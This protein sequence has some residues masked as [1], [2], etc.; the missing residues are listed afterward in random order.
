M[1][2]RIC[3]RALACQLMGAFMADLDSFGQFRA[4]ILD[5]I[6]HIIRACALLAG[7]YLP[8]GAVRTVPDQPR[9]DRRIERGSRESRGRVGVGRIE[10]LTRGS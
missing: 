2:L 1:R 10:Q 8:Q 3:S 4:Q 6:L 9:L 5:A 7:T